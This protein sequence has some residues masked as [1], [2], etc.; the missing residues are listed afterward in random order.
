M[1]AIPS[2]LPTTKTL[3]SFKEHMDY[4]RVKPVLQFWKI[5]IPPSL[6]KIAIR[7]AGSSWLRNRSWD[8]S[9]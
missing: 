6:V 7:T 3:S 1:L 5:L 4:F 8:C 9:R 2:C